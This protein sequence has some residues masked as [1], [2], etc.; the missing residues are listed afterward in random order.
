[1][2]GG[3]VAALLLWLA[4]SDP[5]VWS[6][7]NA[8]AEDKKPE[9][10]KRQYLG[11]SYCSQ[12]HEK[13]PTRNY[14]DDYVLLTEYHTWS[15]KDKHSQ[16][17]KVLTE[18]RSKRMGELLNIKDVTKDARCLNCHAANVPAETRQEETFKISDGVSC[19]AC[20]GPSS[21]WIVP[22]SFKRWRTVPIADKE[23]LG[24]IDVRD[25]VKRSKM[26]FSCHI[27]NASEG[28]VVTHDMYAAGHPPL[29]GIEV[30]T[31]SE[32]MPR[33]WRYNREKTKKIQELL[34]VDSSELEQT[35]LTVLGN[36]VALRTAMEL[37]HKQTAEQPKGTGEKQ[38]WPELA[39]F[40]CYACHHD[41][42][43]PSWRQRRGYV[44][45]PGRPQ[46]REWPRELVKLGLSSAGEKEGDANRKFKKIFDAFDAQPFGKPTQIRSA[47]GD[48][49]D[50]SDGLIKQLSTKKFTKTAGLR[51]L[52]KLCSL[53]RGQ[54][55]DY[56]SAR[57]IAWAFRIIY[58]ETYGNSES[59]P[60]NDQKIQEVL[61]QLERELHLTL[62]AGTKKSIVVQLPNSLKA[63]SDYDPYQFRKQ[64]RA[65]S[66]LLPGGTD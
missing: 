32:Q 8:R 47:S 23:K 13:G 53:S 31:F 7:V 33:H 54:L 36:V 58:G 6:E 37:L 11:A 10:A 3:F 51:L 61:G 43:T 2:C 59:K 48:I 25:P 46:M 14:T 1:M 18:P 60:S 38:T 45:K 62:P 57:Q 4:R 19:D 17:Y 50:W 5:K 12:C 42:K 41:L 24:M 66:K 52:Q 35:K 20:H 44:G 65:L 34:K 26:C 27:G 63:I 22:H 55:P 49:R 15:E 30:S 16:A 29:P 39:Q 40:D 56:H 21:D 9:V 64:L 28:K